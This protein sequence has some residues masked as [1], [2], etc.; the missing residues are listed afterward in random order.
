MT[1]SVVISTFSRNLY[2]NELINSIEAQN[3][4]P[5]EII[6]IEAGT[7]S[8]F[9]NL[10]KLF[11]YNSLIRL[12]HH[13]RSSLGASRNFGASV[14][15]TDF[16]FFSDDDD[17][18]RSDKADKVLNLLVENS[19]VSHSASLFPKQR[20]FL[21][22]LI[23]LNVISI[24]ANLWGNRFGGGSSLCCHKDL[25]KFIPF[26][27][28]MRS[29]EDIEW[30]IR[31]LFAETKIGFVDEPLVDYR[32]NSINKMGFN[33]KRNLTWDLFLVRKISVIMFGIFFGIQ[34]KLVRNLIRFVFRR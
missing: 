22:S 4:K 28:V 12:Y 34:L 30:I 20:I 23:E 11:Q 10:K 7:K 21:G 31:C 17:I 16:V 24:A 29:C 3:T 27:E 32:V 2:L 19:L 8:D 26:N 15:K 6:I 25:V 13:E 18:W 1:Y 14:A 33:V 9:E 5:V